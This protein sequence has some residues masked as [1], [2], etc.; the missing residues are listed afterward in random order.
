MFD[1]R[2]LE[3]PRPALASRAER[4]A[5]LHHAP[6]VVAAAPDEIDHLPQVLPDFARPE[7]LRRRIE[8]ELPDLPMAEGPDLSAGILAAG[9]GIIGRDQ[10]GAV[11]FRMVDIQPQDRT[12]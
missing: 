7:P 11:A 8:G 4:V 5:S 9:E 12:D 6:A 1:N 2:R 10:I 3:G